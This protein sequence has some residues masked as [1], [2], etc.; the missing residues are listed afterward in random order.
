MG[1]LVLCLRSDMMENVYRRVRDENKTHYIVDSWCRVLKDVLPFDAHTICSNRLFVTSSIVGCI[2]TTTSV[3]RDN[4]HL[5]ETLRT[6]GNI[7]L[8]TTW[9]TLSFSGG[10][11]TYDGIFVDK[12]CH[13]RRVRRCIDPSMCDHPIHIL[14]VFAPASCWPGICAISAQHPVSCLHNAHSQGVSYAHQLLLSPEVE[15]W[16]HL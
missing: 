16:T 15:Q 10:L 5:L 9:P 12:L 7:P 2:A 4:T 11:P 13:K 3:F 14:Q 1:A 8:V 6:S